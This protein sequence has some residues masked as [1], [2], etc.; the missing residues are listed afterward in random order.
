M[1]GRPRLA[2]IGSGEIAGFHVAA[3]RQAGFVV[4]HIAARPSSTT[5]KSFAKRFEIPQVWEDPSDLIRESNL[6]D[7]VILA[8]QT[9]AMVPLLELAIETGKPI[10]A[11][12][13]VGLTSGALSHLVDTRAPVMVGF[14]RR[15]YTPVQAASEFIKN[16]GPCLMHLELPE[17]VPLDPKT[18]IRN[19]R[20]VRLNSVHG[21]DLVNYL[22]SGL[23]T[24]DVHHVQPVDEKRG[25]VVVLKSARGDLC[26]ISANWNA[27]ANFSLVIDRDDERFELRPL[28]YGAIY[29][30]MRVVEPT[31]E[32]PI[33][34]Y[35]PQRVAEI[36]PD[37]DS[38]TF[39]PGFVAQCYALLDLIG[40]THSPI[41][42]KLSDAK[43]ALEI[44]ELIM[45]NG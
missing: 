27:P 14:N 5:T 45:G 43:F 8:V 33:R 40:G 11:E 34:K 29:R 19:L 13:P 30:G 15:F 44:A 36:L 7:A 17:D 26:T 39:K 28:E 38:I 2:I 12:K 6:W 35:L 23:T 42:A 20:S 32:T 3:A 25:G 10:L 31:T 18:S 4:E 22:A 1:T 9:E 24:L 21:F 37:Q 41:A 16:G